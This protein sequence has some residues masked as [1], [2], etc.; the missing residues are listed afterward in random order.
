MKIKTSIIMIFM[1][2]ISWFACLN[3][4]VYGQ[5]VNP[6][7]SKTDNSSETSVV[8]TLIAF[9]RSMEDIKT[10]IKDK[11]KEY[12]SADIEE[13]KIKIKEEISS[14]RQKMETYDKDF[15]RIATNVDWNEL[16]A[17]GQQD[18]DWQKE[19]RD[20][21]RP[22]I[23]GL[24]KITERP[25]KIEKLRSE[26]DFHEKRLA[27]LK[28]A[29]E[30]VQKIILQSQDTALSQKLKAL[31]KKW[32]EKEQ[33]ISNQLTVTR[34]HLDEKLNQK[35]SVWQS[36]QNVLQIFFKSRGRNLILS[37]LAFVSAFL[38]LRMTYRFISKIIPAFKAEIRPFYLRL[39]EAA[40]LFLTYA[41]SVCA[42][43]T[44]LY[45][46][47]DWILLSLVIIFAVGIAWATKQGISQFWE[48]T[49]LLLNIGAVRDNERIMYNGIP[50]RVASL[51]IYSQLENPCLTA[52]RIRIPLE[53]L[54]GQVSR[55]YHKDEPWFPCQTDDWVI[56]S[57]GTFGKVGVQT[58]EFVQLFCGNMPKTYLTQDF[59]GLTPGNLSKGFFLT[60]TFGIDYAHQSIIT[61]EVPEKMKE[62]L[63]EKLAGE[64]F[65]E[66]VTDLSVQFKEA[67]ASSLDI[68]IIASFTGKV[69][70]SY[71]KL[72]RLLQQIAVET[73]TQNGWG[74]PFPQITY[75]YR[76][77]SE[78]EATC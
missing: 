51:N 74:I 13:H 32:K 52:P 29:V 6:S 17:G 47:N 77:A 12:K 71:G 53:E 41:G 67:G 22:V 35:T 15:E 18:F 76:D 48:Q 72:N 26:L 5:S 3:V 31:D 24:K 62:M 61:K 25:M 57:D 75:S 40:Y 65:K 58:Q 68:M 73:A 54:I 37:L 60:S 4:S 63:M 78:G 38:L 10:E 1:I 44:V 16:D 39:F 34:H 19:I 36:G 30:N 66:D 9:I 49:K 55:P 11:E 8:S 2:Y 27:A 46:L 23:N 42:L 56:L 21:F 14:L 59:L 70:S 33:Q 45:V 28:D 20:I 64:G 50:W 43:L 7:L 69:A